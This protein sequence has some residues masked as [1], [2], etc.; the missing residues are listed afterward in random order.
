MQLKKR[1]N[2]KCRDCYLPRTLLV[3]DR[4]H[5]YY[6]DFLLFATIISK[7]YFCF[8]Y[9]IDLI[10]KLFTDCKKTSQSKRLK[11]KFETLSYLMS[12]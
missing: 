5:D 8:T 6:F 2:K 9:S 1:M 12:P 10:L 11:D 3:N 7:T 4:D